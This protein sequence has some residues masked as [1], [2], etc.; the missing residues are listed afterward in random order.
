MDSRT[1]PIKSASVIVPCRGE[2]PALRAC[3]AALW[4]QKADVRFEI[5]VCVNGPAGP[6]DANLRAVKVVYEPKPGAAAAR[7]TGVR[8]ACGDVLAFLDSDCTAAPGWLASALATLCAYQGRCVAGGRIRR[9][10]PYRN[11]VGLYDAASY[12]QQESYIRSSGACVTAN[13]A[14]HRSVF[15]SVG[16]FD[17]SFTEAACEDWEWTTRARR[18]GYPIVY[19]RR[20]VVYHPCMS[21]V[22]ELK[23]KAERLSRGEWLLRSKTDGDRDSPGLAAGIGRQIRRAWRDRRLS[24][25]D[26]FRVMCVGIAVAVWSWR[27][28]GRMRRV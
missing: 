28:L 1:L 18:M 15:D 11:W 20:A 19:S 24:S 26:R 27:E 2:W 23:A 5:V 13:L 10:R 16:P 9:T 21:R 22:S 3:L 6:P 14:V 12:L 4:R 17:E 25:W 8:A 7:N